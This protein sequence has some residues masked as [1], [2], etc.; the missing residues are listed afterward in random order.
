MP[1]RLAPNAAENGSL[2]TIRSDLLQR[3][4]ESG[5]IHRLRIDDEELLR[6][7]VYTVDESQIH[8]CDPADCG[9]YAVA[10]QRRPQRSVS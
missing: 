9:P 4:V 5:F 1:F 8:Q 6:V 7:G 3:T 2:L 10:V